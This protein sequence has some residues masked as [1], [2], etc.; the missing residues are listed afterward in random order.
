MG[1][2]GALR[3]RPV[4]EPCRGP[5]R[6][7]GG[8]NGGRR[9]CSARPP[10]YRHFRRL[11][12]LYAQA[13]MTQ[14]AQSTACNRLHAA[15][16]RL[17]RWLLICRD[18]VGRDDDADHPGDD[19]RDA[20]RAAGHGDRGR[21]RA[22]ARRVSSVT[23]AAWS[24]SWTGRAGSRDVRVLPDRAGGVRPPA[25]GPRRLSVERATVLVVDDEGMVRALVRRML[26]PEVCGVV[27]A[28]DGESGAPAHRARPAGDRR[29]ADRP[30]HAGH[31]R[32]RHHHGAGQPPPGPARRR[33]C[34]A[35]PQRRRAGCRCPSSRSRSRSSAPC[36]TARAG[37]P[38]SRE[39]RSA[40]Q[41]RPQDPAGWSCGR[42]RTT[43][44]PGVRCQPRRRISAWSPRRC[45]L[46]RQR[47][48]PPG[49]R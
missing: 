40:W 5:G 47:A 29:R 30:R 9:R 21:Q 1:L 13:F 11:L 42:R 19:G 45:E 14:I 43:S 34:R 35:S 26:E 24:R 37:A 23:A 10:A 20:R 28:E 41:R 17:A 16:Q 38:R 2:P 6:R 44:P 18:R 22:A 46:R 3:R 48:E 33:A 32:V 49:A 12:Y 31:R 7:R 36:A 39:L 15:E 25:R 27:E 4:D 8:A